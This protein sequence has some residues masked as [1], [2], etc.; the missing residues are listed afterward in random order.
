M[1]FIL[2]LFLSFA[3][4]KNVWIASNVTN[5]TE[6]GEYLGMRHVAHVLGFDVF[7]AQT[8]PTP[9]QRARSVTSALFPDSK[10]TQFK[11][12]FTR[13]SDP[14]YPMQWNLFRVNDGFSGP[15]TGKGVAI[16]IVDDGI[17]YSH[18]DLEANFDA[19]LSYDYNHNQLNVNP[20][21]TDGHGTAAAGVCCAVANNVCG[22]G[23]AHNAKIAGIRLIAE[24]T[25]DYVEALAILHKRDKIRIK[26]SSWGP[27]DDGLSLEK[28]GR[29]MERALWEESI[30]IFASGNGRNFLDDS[31][32]DGYANHPNV[33]AIGAIDKNG[34][35]AYYSEGGACLFAVVPSS[36]AGVGVI[37][38]DLMGDFG[39]SPGMCTSDFGGTSAAAPLA[40]GIFA[41]LLEARPELKTRDIQ[42]I[43]AKTAN[44]VHSHEF[45]FGLLK[46]APLLA[47]AKTHTLV[48][49][50]K[51]LE[52]GPFLNNVAIPEDGSWRSQEV[53]I[54]TTVTFIERVLV[55]VS[56]THSCRGQLLIELGDSKLATF[57]HD[58]Y[59]GS[60]VWT[61][62]TVRMWSKAGG[63]GVTLRIRDCVRDGKVGMVAS[64][65]I[66]ILYR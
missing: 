39:Y 2:L 32:F 27:Q 58:A 9:A 15:E 17:Q 66:Q 1:R 6:Y 59:N 50:Q 24:A 8:E 36:G 61:F 18:P 29:I 56:I 52:L 22:A 37:T 63:S 16:G 64:V 62:S 31:N 13:T 19:S 42:E 33:I 21:N 30:N 40:A 65:G 4:A 12:I 26:S 25:Y 35:R 34:N 57:R 38:S 43:V 45:G 20:Y 41:I 54:P 23:V 44:Y 5:A 14:M 51:K 7:A 46:I 48:G 60:F 3:V 28:P 10:R 49:P 47:T 53:T 11:R 55:T